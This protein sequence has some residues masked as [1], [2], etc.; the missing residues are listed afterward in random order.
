MTNQ[1]PTVTDTRGRSFACFAGALLAFIVNEDERILML[2]SPK[3][4]GQWEVI[5]GALDAGETLLDGVLREVREEVGSA[6]QVRPLGV[7]HAYTYRW[8][9]I[10]QYL[11]SIAFLLAYEGG[12]IQPGDDMAGSQFRWVSVEEVERGEIEVLVPEATVWMCRHAIALYRLLKDQPPAD[13][14]P[15][16]DASTKNKYKQQ[17]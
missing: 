4:P 10:V 6:V 8:D 5:N 11:M 12:E 7:V 3:R 15:L 1:Q 17:D 14:Q 9:D 2:S 13:L 16:F